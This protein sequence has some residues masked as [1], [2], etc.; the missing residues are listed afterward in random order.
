MNNKG[1]TL[2]VNFLLL[3]FVIILGTIVIIMFKTEFIEGNPE[4]TELEERFYKV[5]TNL[6]EDGN[7]DATVVSIDVNQGE[8][9]AYNPNSSDK[10]YY[11]QLDEYSK[12]IYDGLYNNKE[13]MKTGTSQIDLD[14][15]LAKY[16]TNKE[17]EDKVEGLFTLA[18]TAFECDNPDVFYID[19]SKMV[20]YYEKNSLGKCK[21]YVKSDDNKGNYLV[22]GFNGK[23]DVDTAINTVN[24]IANGIVD[25]TKGSGD[26][27]IIRDIHEWIVKN[28][29]YDRTV[30]KANRNN[31]YGL[32][33]ER[34]AT[35]GGYAKG[36]KYL[37]DRFGIETIVIQGE[38]TRDGNSEFHAWDYVKTDGL[39]YAIDCT[40]DDP[41]V[42]GV[43][44]ENKKVYYDYFLKNENSFNDHTKFNTFYGTDLKITYPELSTNNY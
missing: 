30:S 38:A 1:R 8:T 13:N 18:V 32:F 26:Y 19:F 29:K 43:A 33:V 17:N 41:I 42:E 27:I 3:F 11:N 21:A 24:E 15:D 28:A 23:E 9:T 12:K 44:E 7:S 25:S 40:W 20:L 6:P 10:F 16:L 22:D 35:C 4:A 39:W 14:N 34:E 5:T 31:I 37:M 36:F 2:I